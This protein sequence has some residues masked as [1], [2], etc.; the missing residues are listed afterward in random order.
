MTE[1]RLSALHPVQI[2]LGLVIWSLWFVAI[3]AGLSV[4]CAVAPPPPGTGPLNGLNLALGLLTLVTLLG[5]LWLARRFWRMTAPG[6]TLNARQAFVTRMA[7]GMHLI[8]ALATLF[9][10]LPLL[11]LPPCV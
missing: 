5:L 4:A 11:W 7:A 3:Y 2:P 10:G 1:P 9:V 8:A 6:H